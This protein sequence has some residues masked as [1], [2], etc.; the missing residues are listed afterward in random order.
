M[1]RLEPLS[2]GF[3]SSVLHDSV[4]LLANKHFGGLLDIHVEPVSGLPLGYEASRQ[5]V[6]F[7]LKQDGASDS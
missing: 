1:L 3:H 2:R 4:P 5:T 6:Y 7:H